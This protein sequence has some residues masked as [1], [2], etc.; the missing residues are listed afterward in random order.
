M[1]IQRPPIVICA[2]IHPRRSMRSVPR[3]PASRPPCLPGSLPPCL[4]ASLPPCLPASLLACLPARPPALPPACLPA[5]LPACRPACL[6]A[7][8]PFLLFTRRWRAN[9][10]V[11]TVPRSG[12]PLAMH[13]VPRLPR[14]T[15]TKRPAAAAAAVCTADSCA[16]AAASVIPAA[17]GETPTPHCKSSGSGY[18]GLARNS[19]PISQSIFSTSAVAL[20]WL[21]RP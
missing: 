20:F 12:R 7:C 13:P 6:P 19:K 10:A 14:G 4:P 16:A 18:S 15:K 8:L 3:L 11:S 9:V 1:T 5:C 2:H 17:G 21:W